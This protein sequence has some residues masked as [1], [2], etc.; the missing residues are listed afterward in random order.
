MSYPNTIKQFVTKI[1]K[2]ASGWFVGPEYFNVPSVSPYELYLDH[3]PRD[4]ATTVVGASGAV[5]P[6]LQIYSGTPAK[7]QFLVDYDYGKV[8]FA[9]ANAGAAAR[10]SYYNLGD[11]IMAEHVNTLQDEVELI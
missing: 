8:T 2:N 7:N 6:W 5:V 10:A 3:V 9:A 11:D 1:D 4:S